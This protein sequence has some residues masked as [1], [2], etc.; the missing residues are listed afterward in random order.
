MPPFFETWFILGLSPASALFSPRCA[1]HCRTAGEAR[2][3]ARAEQPCS[4]L[5][6]RRQSLATPLRTAFIFTLFGAHRALCT[7]PRT[8]PPRALLSGWPLSHSALTAL[9]RV[10]GVCAPLLFL[11]RCP[12]SVQRGQESGHP[13]SNI[14]TNGSRAACR[15]PPCPASAHCSLCAAAERAAG[16]ACLSRCKDVFHTSPQTLHVGSGSHRHSARQVQPST[17]VLC[18]TPAFP[19]TFVLARKRTAVT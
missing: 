6:P 18:S 13:E 10:G 19:S 16:R 9:R 14:R 4:A 1:K 17:A 8:G 3:V 5:L 7:A 12:C 11:W 15:S 2:L